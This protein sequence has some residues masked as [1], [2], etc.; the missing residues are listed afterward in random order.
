[1]PELPEVETMR[2]GV[3]PV[4]GMTIQAIEQPR[5]RVRPIAITPALP[6]FRRRVAGRKI[7][8]T[9]RVGKRVILELDSDDRIVFE[10]RMAGLV[11]MA[12]PPTREHLRL[13]FRLAKGKRTAE[14][15][16]WDRRGLGSVR[17]VDEQEFERR[18]GAAKI[19]PDALAISTEEL[20]ERLSS[21]RRPIKVA[22]LDQRAVAGIGNLYAS[23]ILHLAKVDPRRTCD[24][25][26]RAE[27]K[28]IHAA[29]VEI[30]E[31]AIE[32]EGST[33]GDGTYRNAQSKAGRY[34]NRH[35]VYGRKG[36]PCPVCKKPVERI[37]QAQRST[38]FCP[39]C[40][41]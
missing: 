31:M 28:A 38:F 19:G 15:M 24:R 33:L 4:V 16:Y 11:L 27:W 32:H 13:V 34:Q 22:L 36:Q 5:L 17:L 12:E 8:G 6:A 2:R 20:R 14:L 25:L 7:V 40:Q 9:D 29:T 1:M 41:K 3:E 18:Y 10:P 35:R 26:R 21:S 39:R 23:E 30:L 37:V